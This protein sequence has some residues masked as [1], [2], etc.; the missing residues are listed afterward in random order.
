MSAASTIQILEGGWLE[1]GGGGQK[2]KKII[3]QICD[4]SYLLC[5]KGAI[6]VIRGSTK[7]I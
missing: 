6:M 5:P 2:F 7:A 1:L 3:F 4:V